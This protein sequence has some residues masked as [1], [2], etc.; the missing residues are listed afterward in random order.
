MADQRLPKG[1]TKEDLE[2]FLGKSPAPVQEGKAAPAV[3]EAVEQDPFP[4]PLE[5]RMKGMDYY[6]QKEAWFKGNPRGR[7]RFLEMNPT[8]EWDEE[9]QDFVRKG[10]KATGASLE[11]STT[12]LEEVGKSIGTALWG[13]KSKMK[14]WADMSGYERRGIVGEALHQFT[15]GILTP[16]ERNEAIE[17]LAKTGGG[18]AGAWQ[19]GKIGAKRGPV[20]AL[21]GGAIGSSIGYTTSQAVQGKGMP[22]PGRQTREL[23][24]GITPPAAKSVALTQKFGDKLPRMAGESSRLI[25]QVEGAEQAESLMDKGEVLPFDPVRTGASAVLGAGSAA[26]QKG[27]PRKVDPKILQTEEGLIDEGVSAAKRLGV[28]EVIPPDAKTLN[29]PHIKQT[30]FNRQQLQRM[31]FPVEHGDPFKKYERALQEGLSKSAQEVQP[32]GATGGVRSELIR[33]SIMKELQPQERTLAKEAQKAYEKAMRDAGGQIR[34]PSGI[35][36]NTVMADARKSVQSAIARNKK[37]EQDSYA[38]LLKQLPDDEFVSLNNNF[39]KAL[40]QWEKELPTVLKKAK[41]GASTLKSGLLNAQG[42]D[43]LSMTLPERQKEIAKMFKGIEGKIGVYKEL[44]NKPHTFKEAQ[45]IKSEIGRELGAFKNKMLVVAPG[46]DMKDFSTLYG[47]LKDDVSGSI[48]SLGA[49]SASDTVKFNKLADDLDKLQAWKKENIDLY[50]RTDPWFQKLSG[51]VVEGGELEVGNLGSE[52]LQGKGR[53]ERLLHLKKLMPE[54]Y[55]NLRRGLQDELMDAQ[56]FPTASGQPLID[57]EVV[58]TRLGKLGKGFKD[59]LFGSPE[60]YAQVQNAV[61][62]FKS[63]KPHYGKFGGRALIPQEVL[64]ELEEALLKGPEAVKTVVKNVE[65]AIK[66]EAKRTKKFDNDLYKA[67]ST[68]TVGGENFVRGNKED[69]IDH[70]VFRND[71]PSLVKEWISSLPPDLRKELS[72]EVAHHIYTKS[73]NIAA[74]PT[75]GILADFALKSKKGKKGAKEIVAKEVKENDFI[76]ELYGDKNRRRVL[77]QVLEPGRLQKLDDWASVFKLL[78]RRQKIA[79]SVGAFGAETSQPYGITAQIKA[80]KSKLILSDPI[81]AFVSGGA[82]NPEGFSQVMGA[83]GK[84]NQQSLPE[85][86]RLAKETLSKQGAP[87]ATLRI[88]NSYLKAAEEVPELRTVIE[89]EAA[90]S[91]EAIRQGWEQWLKEQEADKTNPDQ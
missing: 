11:P 84:F 55:D 21:I 71:D 26:L 81:Q 43:L 1:W 52:L 78:G 77:E 6:D 87:E 18:L 70:L 76:K 50:E 30:A 3:V 47:S 39:V 19:G 20:W 69:F 91:K 90:E 14:R 10:H 12:K 66:A 5:K 45:R 22:T 44:A 24:Y 82:H 36:L 25:A 23:L 80:L 38:D 73:A 63:L 15:G 67:F 57:L 35:E 59:E 41:K 2:R 33:Q 85:A 61:N 60:A 68:E 40:T 46:H 29:V 74:S 49:G 8:M 64:G 51:K 28:P 72:D 79:G 27:V 58:S 53:I 86:G 88:L 37:I 62:D 7:E 65:R 31:K 83:L 56:T 89:P 4:H 54:G 17:E 16:D 48:R 32:T 13:D 34:P 42:D 9:S 75:K